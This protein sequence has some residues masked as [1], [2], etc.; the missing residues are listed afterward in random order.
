[1][2]QRTADAIPRKNGCDKHVV[3]KSL[4]G[5]DSGDVPPQLNTYLAMALRFMER[6]KRHTAPLVQQEMI[7]TGLTQGRLPRCCL[8]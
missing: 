5:F 2:S 4:L 1:M 3:G 6:G 7:A 8:G